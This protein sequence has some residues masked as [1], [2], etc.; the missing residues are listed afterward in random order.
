[1]INTITETLTR[2]GSVTTNKERTKITK[3]LY[4]TLK[5]INNTNRNSRL[6]KTQKEQFLRKLIDQNNL[7]LKKNDLC[8]VIMMIYSI[9]E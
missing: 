4:E 2:L 5:N 9:K 8:I 6:R 1:M 7:L 3:E